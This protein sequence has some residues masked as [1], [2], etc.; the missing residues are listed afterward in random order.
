MLKILDPPEGCLIA[1]AMTSTQ[2]E[3]DP[4]MLR[5]IDPPEEYLI[6]RAMTDLFS[7]TLDF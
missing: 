3:F 1:R 4:L 7:Q 5:I 2:H 6:A